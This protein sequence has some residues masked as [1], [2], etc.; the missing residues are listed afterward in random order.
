MKSPFPGMDPYLEAQWTDVHAS[1]IVYARDQLRPILPTDL[2]V[3]IEGTVNVALEDAEEVAYKPDLRVY[4]SRH[5]A[6][7]RRGNGGMAVAEPLYLPLRQQPKVRRHLRIIDKKANGRVV[8]AIE[9]LSPW[10]KLGQEARRD[11]RSKR[12]RFRQGGANFVEIDLHRTGPYVLLARPNT[13]PAVEGTTYRACVWRAARPLGVEYYL[14]PLRSKLPKMRI[15]LRKRD[16]DVPLD[17]QALVDEVY[18]RGFAGEIDYAADPTPPLAPKDA[19]WA[20]KLLR[21]KGLR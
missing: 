3:H 4:E 15:P 11:Y 21:S 8:T 12:K 16:A 1:L 9:M 19:A 13:L 14:L 7:D 10:N 6:K 17:L 2:Q 5:K 20:D 18:H